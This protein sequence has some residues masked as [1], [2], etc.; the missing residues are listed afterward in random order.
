[1]MGEFI[2][3]CGL[4][5]CGKSTYTKKL[6]EKDSDVCVVSSDQIREEFAFEAGGGNS[7]VFET[8]RIRTKAA[9]S[10]GKTVVYDATN[11]QRKHRVALLSEV[12]KLCSVCKC[13]LFAEPF[14][15]CQERN[16]QRVVKWV[17]P[18]WV[19]W[20]MLKSFNVPQFCEGFD[21]IEII[22]TQSTPGFTFNSVIGKTVEFEQDNPHHS[23]S[24]Y[25]H[26]KKTY[27]CVKELGG[28]DV[29]QEAAL[30]HD[31]GKLWTKEFKDSQ[32]NETEVAHFYQH[33]NV[34]AYV[35]LVCATNSFKS[36]DVKRILYVAGLINWHMRPY[37]EMNPEKRE[38]E[39]NELGEMFVNDLQLIHQADLKAH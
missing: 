25:D 5:G 28:S 8:M 30:Y 34:G 39:Y 9:L 31:V 32:G 20:R 18:D 3:L 27:E 19:M 38:R 15:V 35:Y 29:C 14:S 13:V 23:L 26:L 7:V 6:I 1:M 10:L 36:S 22:H 37:L 12:K 4:P 2:M 11:L 17:V 16:L 21:Q 33:E 24:L